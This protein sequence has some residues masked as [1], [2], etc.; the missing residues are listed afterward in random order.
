MLTAVTVPLYNALSVI[1][2]SICD[3]TITEEERK[4]NLPKTILRVIKGIFTNPL[5]IACLLGVVAQG[6][7][8]LFVLW[9][10]NWRLSDM[11]FIYKP[12]SWIAPMASPFALL[13]LGGR[14]KFS[15][16]QKLIKP[17]A[18]GTFLRCVFVPVVFLS[19]AYFF[20]PGLEG[21]HF[22]AYVAAFGTPAAVSSA[23]MAI[24]MH[25]DGDLATQ[26]VAWTSLVSILTLFIIIVIFRSIGIF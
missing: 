23:I 4:N 1:A 24:E 7:R 13:V 14:F 6:I 12:L 19:F 10:V 8:A 25:S 3:P 11:T 26:L 9:G 17:I 5:I 22:A 16:A 18:Y 21:Q 15:D 2:L 20:V